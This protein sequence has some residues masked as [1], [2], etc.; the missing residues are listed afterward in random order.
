MKVLLPV[1][2]QSATMERSVD[3]SISSHPKNTD[4]APIPFVFLRNSVWGNGQHLFVST[5]FQNSLK[6]VVVT[7]S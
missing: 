5:Y 1:L 6:P 7:A 2:N 4:I 3:N